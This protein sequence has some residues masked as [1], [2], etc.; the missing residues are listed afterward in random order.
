MSSALCVRLDLRCE[1]ID[2]SDCELDSAK[3][4]IYCDK[5]CSTV[6]PCAELC[7]DLSAMDS[8]AAGACAEP[9]SEAEGGSEGLFVEFPNH[10]QGILPKRSEASNWS[11][12]DDVVVVFNLS[13]GDKMRQ[14]VEIISLCFEG[15][16]W[17]GWMGKVSRS[18][19]T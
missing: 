18:N 4:G 7:V 15:S 12:C 19:P 13:S 14:D 10:H 1:S 2:V 17:I 16:R 3:M 9:E 11:N 6:S 5:L 8:D